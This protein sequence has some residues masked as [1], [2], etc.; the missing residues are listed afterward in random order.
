MSEYQLKIPKGLK[1]T[2]DELWMQYF[3]T[4]YN[5]IQMIQHVNKIIPKIYSDFTNTEIKNL[6]DSNRKKLT[7]DEKNQLKK[8]SDDVKNLIKGKKIKKEKKNSAITEN[9]ANLIME[10][11]NSLVL[12][13]TTL[14]FIHEMSVVYL[15]AIFEDFLE[16]ILYSIFEKH[17]KNIGS[18][19]KITYKEVTELTNL[20]NWNELKKTI[21]YNEI[22]RLIQKGG[23]QEWSKKLTDLKFDL[24]TD[25]SWDEFVE[26][27]ARR[28][29]IV[30]NGGNVNEYY[31]NI[32]N[33]EQG[34]EVKMN[35]GYVYTAVNL[36]E[37][38]GIKLMNL[39]T[40]KIL[41]K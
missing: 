21:I 33:V 10:V 19:K 35:V 20:S 11:T 37:K 30:H 31:S 41:K 14:K 39:H 34:D 2:K 23:I 24:T 5:G 3:A 12:P 26:Y 1:T 9:V 6:L 22:D 32:T 8:I 25:K 13:K 28:N 27:F 17:P 38:F 36:F 7:T 4:F 15:V 18:D 16:K 40:S 29:I